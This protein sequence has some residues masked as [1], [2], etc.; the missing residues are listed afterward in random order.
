[1]T[2]TTTTQN[3]FIQPNIV[4]SRGHLDTPNHIEAG[5]SDIIRDTLKF[6]DGP[7]HTDIPKALPVP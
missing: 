5:R 1:M 7:E 3:R 2:M 4:G 6:G